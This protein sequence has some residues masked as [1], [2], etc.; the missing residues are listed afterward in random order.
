M[1]QA[2]HKTW[3]AV[4]VRWPPDFGPFFKATRGL[5]IGGAILDEVDFWWQ[6]SGNAATEVVASVRPAMAAL[7]GSKLI[8]ISSPYTPT[9]FLYQFHRAHWGRPGRHLVWQA[10]SVAMNPTLNADRIGELVAE[11]P[12]RG[13]AEWEAAWRAGASALF[14]Q[15]GM[16]ERLLRS[17][18]AVLPPV[19]GCQYVAAVDPSGG[20]ADEFAWAVAHRAGDAVTVDLVAGR[21]REGRARSFDLG[22]AVRDCADGLRRYGVRTC[23]GDRY[24]GDWVAREFAKH[25]VTYR[26]SERTKSEA[27]LALV[28][29]V[30][31][32]RI[33]MPSDPE[34]VRQLQLLERRRGI[35][36]KDAVDH[37]VGGHDDRANALALAAHHLVGKPGIAWA[38]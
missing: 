10:A 18:P 12:E 1:S 13:R 27:F 37:P 3:R 38:I 36:G 11:D 14:D 29:L 15:P 8:A 25:G 19:A 24:A 30:T 31:M 17:E 21:R 23:V 22:G 34:L 6:E 35:Q 28:P 16:I 20:G 5:T 2:A 7:P 33:E 9:G 26:P 32:S 4:A